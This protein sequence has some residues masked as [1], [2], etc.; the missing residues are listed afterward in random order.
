M[1]RGKEIGEYSTQATS[2]RVV[3]IGEDRQIEVASEGTVSGQMAGT[4]LITAVFSGPNDRGSYTDCS[5][6]YLETGTAEGS[7]RGAYWLSSTGVWET[8]GIVQLDSGQTVI[9]EGQVKLADRSWSGKLFE[10]E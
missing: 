3:G 1:P 4:V 10:L 6:G 9:A 5:V 8:R 7:G 2:I